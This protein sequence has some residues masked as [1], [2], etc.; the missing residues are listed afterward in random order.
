MP[1]SDRKRYRA[2]FDRCPYRQKERATRIRWLFDVLRELLPLSARCVA[3]APSLCLVCMV[4]LHGRT[5]HRAQ[6]TP[7]TGR[8][9]KP[10]AINS[11][12]FAY[13]LLRRFGFAFFEA[14]KITKNGSAKN[15]KIIFHRPFYHICIY[16][17][18]CRA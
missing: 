17:H 7:S 12:R 6:K 13:H 11:G 15:S 2:K 18:S 9:V 16:R 8:K 5:P 14:L 10:R 1:K 4:C 3:F